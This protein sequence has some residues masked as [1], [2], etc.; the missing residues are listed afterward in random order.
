MPDWYKEKD[1]PVE[2]QILVKGGFWVH[3]NGG[4]GV[5]AT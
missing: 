5:L 4:K 2:F 3:A 1:Q